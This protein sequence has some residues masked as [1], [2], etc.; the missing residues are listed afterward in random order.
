[1]A[2]EFEA[3]VKELWDKEEAEA[4]DLMEQA[5]LQ[6]ED[7]AVFIRK[8]AKRMKEAKRRL[9]KEMCLVLVWERV[10]NL[11]K[12]VERDMRMCYARMQNLRALMNE[13][14]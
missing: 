13:E 9:A 4:L 3:K 2:E 8:R 12:W 5:A 14:D 6:A 11:R 10:G 7:L 1:M